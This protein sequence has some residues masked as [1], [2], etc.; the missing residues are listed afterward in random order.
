MYVRREQHAVG[1]GFFHTT[2]FEPMGD[3]ALAAF[4]IIYDCGAFRYGEASRL[5][6]E[7]SRYQKNFGDKSIDLLVV[8]H[9][10][11]D[12]ISGLKRMFDAQ[13]L[14]R[15]VLMPYVSAIERLLV[16]A[17]HPR[18]STDSEGLFLRALA[19][20]PTA[21]M[22]SLGAERVIFVSGTDGDQE[23]FRDEPQQIDDPRSDD[24]RASND[25]ISGE[26]QTG[27]SSPSFSVDFDAPPQKQADGSELTSDQ[28]SIRIGVAGAEP[29]LVKPF[30]DEI[31]KATLNSFHDELEK[32]LKPGEM[33]RIEDTNFLAYMVFKEAAKL[34]NAYKKVSTDLNVT[35]LSLYVGPPSSSKGCT[36]VEYGDA[37]NADHTCSDRRGWLGT[38]D[39]ALADGQRRQRFLNHYRDEHD[40]VRT[41]VLPHHGSDENFHSE[42]LT[43]FTPKLVIASAASYPYRPTWLHPGPK[44]KQHARGSQVPLRRVTE[45]SNSFLVEHLCPDSCVFV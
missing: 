23:T 39:A 37:Q 19:I 11:L 26:P 24:G 1:Q 7:I 4:K 40:L 34:R 36:W 2:N 6:Q 29:W 12:H 17:S 18:V 32:Q 30:V 13:A 15:A 42:L 41:L 16:F 22:R 9:A 38:G 45:K 3:G 21:A 10:H 33:A 27:D 43:T 25:E 14:P 31:D 20:D 44:V 8:S 35:S 28:N 5:A